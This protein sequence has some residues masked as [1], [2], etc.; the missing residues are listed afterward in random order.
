[1]ISRKFLFRLVI[2][3]FSL[4]SPWTTN[5]AQGLSSQPSSISFVSGGIDLE[6]QNLPD[7][8]HPYHEKSLEMTN[9]ALDDPTLLCTRAVSYGPMEQQLLDVWAPSSGD[10][11][12]RAIVVFI[13]GGGW[14]W[15]YREYVGFC[16]KNVCNDNNAIMVAPS[17]ALGKG[18]SKAWPQSRDDIV[19]VLRWITDESNDLIQS[20]GGNPT[21]IILAG[22]SAGGHLAACVGLDAE[23]LS[24]AGIDPSIIKALF[25]ISCP[26]GIRE[27]DFFGAL[28]KRRWLWRT[29]GGPLARFIY[30]RVNLKFLRPMVGSLRESDNGQAVAT[31]ASIR[32]DAEDASPLGW[33]VDLTNGDSSMSFSLVHYSYAK[34]KDFFIC[35]PHASSL[36]NILGESNVQVLEMPVVGHFE[37][38]FSLADPTC[39]WHEA[40]RKTMASL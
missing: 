30:K 36:A 27:E 21:K 26:L 6:A 14:D 1:M 13:H 8:L 40:F 22:H 31:K 10:K 35:P 39:E 29:V 2:T 20:N 9:A 19:E 37:S 5:L 12:D 15:G 25:L 18:T 17:Y 23:L 34:E 7:F 24:N 3:I 33:L 28:A 16:A 4:T 11:G 38:H 32:N